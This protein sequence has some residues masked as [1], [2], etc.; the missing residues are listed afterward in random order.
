MGV[1]L[2]FLLL[3]VPSSFA[4]LGLNAAN[5]FF[6]SSIFNRTV[7]G[8]DCPA[9]LMVSWPADDS[10]VDIQG[11]N[12]LV[13]PTAAV[14]YTNGI[15]NNGFWFKTGHFGYL[16][17]KNGPDISM[18]PGVNKSWSWWMW[19]AE[20]NN[21][22]VAMM[23]KQNPG[24]GGEEYL[25]FLDSTT[26]LAFFL[27]QIDTGNTSLASAHPIQVSNW[28]HIVITYD[29]S[30]GA[31]N[32]YQ[33]TTNSNTTATS[34]GTNQTSTL[35]LGIGPV[36]SVMWQGVMDEFQIY[37]NVLSASDVSVLYN[38]GLAKRCPP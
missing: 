12:D 5:P 13:E 28:T 22:F 3:L 17:A 25:A 15:I 33:N 23:A 11:T 27:Y 18:G 8:S 2:L 31:L 4:Q 29:A 10:R 32:M 16:E 6:V 20:T 35:L 34:N 19:P 37:S 30:S 26:S 38:S 21:I 1:R 14:H 36:S 24:G 7:S 9:G